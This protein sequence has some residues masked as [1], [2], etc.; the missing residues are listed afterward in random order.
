MSFFEFLCPH[1]GG[2]SENWCLIL[3]YA[4]QSRSFVQS[5][6]GTQI[7]FFP[8]LHQTGMPGSGGCQA[9]EIFPVSRLFPI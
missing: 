2:T 6:L 4:V 3:Y 7:S 8:P 9:S 1:V 5:G